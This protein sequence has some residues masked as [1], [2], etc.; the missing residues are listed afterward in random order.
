MAEEGTA[1]IIGY[2][3]LCTC[4]VETTQLPESLTKKLP[5]YAA[6]PGML[7]GRL[8]VDVRYQGQRMGTRLVADALKRCV[9]LSNDIAAMAVLVDAKDDQAAQFYEHFGFQRFADR[10]LSLFMTMRELRRTLG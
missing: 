4:S 9:R 5:R 2:Y 3:S 1:R 10:P 8:A 6:L 7:L